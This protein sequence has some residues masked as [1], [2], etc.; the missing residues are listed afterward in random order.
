[1]LAVKGSGAKVTYAHSGTGGASLV[2]QTLFFGKAGVDATGVPFT[3]GSQILTAVLG[4]QVDFGAGP[5]SE[6]KSQI[7]AGT[8]RVL[9]LFA[10]ERV[11]ILPDVPTTAEKGIDVEIAQMRL[12]MAPAGLPAGVS[13]KI[14]AAAEEAIR[15][16]GYQ[17]FLEQNSILESDLEGAEVAADIERTRE[18]I[19]AGFEAIGYDPEAQE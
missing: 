2:G 7:D 18:K 17:D 3:G 16:P 6:V 11:D 10:A 8:V 15:S 9:G 5:I 19:G 12:L 13:E 1:V 14:T 4:G